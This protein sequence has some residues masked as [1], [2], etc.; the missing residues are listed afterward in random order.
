MTLIR[1]CRHFK[2]NFVVISAKLIYHHDLEL[3]KRIQDHSKLIS[4]YKVNFTDHTLNA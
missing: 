3:S 2:V 4:F 1:F